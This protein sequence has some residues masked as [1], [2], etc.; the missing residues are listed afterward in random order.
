MI[1]LIIYSPPT[2][3]PLGRGRRLVDAAV[4][5]AIPFRSAIADGC[6]HV[7][8]LCN[9]R[10]LPWSS[11]SLGVRMEVRLGGWVAGCEEGR[12]SGQ[13]KVVGPEEIAWLWYAHVCACV[14]P[15]GDSLWGSFKALHSGESTACPPQ[16]LCAQVLPATQPCDEMC[17]ARALRSAILRMATCDTVFLNLLCPTGGSEFGG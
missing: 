6:T 2:P 17:A 10:L 13:G 5:E 14:V 15:C 9:R 12:A 16:H 3:T 7:L 11:W 1:Y 8:T 4:F